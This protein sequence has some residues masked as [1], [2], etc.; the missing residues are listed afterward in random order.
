VRVA[1]APES[2]GESRNSYLFLT[3]ASCHCGEWDWLGGYCV[4]VCF[5]VGSQAVA[6]DYT[7]AGMW[8]CVLNTM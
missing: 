4:G 6:E 8:Y 7:D 2:N 5:V 3:H 1:L